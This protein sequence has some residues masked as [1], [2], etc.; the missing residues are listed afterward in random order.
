M[1][2]HFAV[3]TFYFKELKMSAFAFIWALSAAPFVVQYRFKQQLNN[4][5]RRLSQ[6]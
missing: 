3:E 4:A 5:I 1:I 6:L 2:V